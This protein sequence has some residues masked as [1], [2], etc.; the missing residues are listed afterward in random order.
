MSRRSFEMM[1]PVLEGQ[2][3]QPVYLP[4]QLG[5]DAVNNDNP[6]SVEPGSAIAVQLV[7][8]DYQASAIGTVTWVG[9]GYFLAFGHSFMNKGNVEYNVFQADVLQTIKSQA[10]SLKMGAAIR[11]IGKIVEDR[12][13]GILGRFGTSPSMIEVEVNVKDADQRKSLTSRFRVVD[14]ERL[15]P[16]LIISGVTAAIDRTI[17]RVGEGT[18]K[19]TVRFVDSKNNELTVRDNVFFGKDIA[20]TCVKDITSLLDIFADNEFDHVDLH[21]VKVDVQVK[22]ANY[23]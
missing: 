10:M 2:H 15:Y 3:L 8:G 17:D 9:E 16:D 11:P 12:H 5:G 23:G 14:M 1:R 13:A 7:S 22:N 20:V 4:G 19:V 21:S 6:F 18:A